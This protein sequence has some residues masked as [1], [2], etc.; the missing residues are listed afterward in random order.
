MQAPIETMDPADRLDFA[1]DFVEV[2]DRAETVAG[3]TWGL[4]SAAT[5]AGVEI[6]AQSYSR[7]TATVWLQVASGSR[8]SSAWNGDGTKILATCVATSSAGRIRERAITVTIKQRNVID[9]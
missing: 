5:S 7:T 8:S 6:Y 2:F 4:S 3:A 1:V 9:G